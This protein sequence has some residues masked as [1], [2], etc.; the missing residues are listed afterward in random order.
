MLS[1]EN[2][3]A[4]LFNGPTTKKPPSEP[5]GFVDDSAPILHGRI[6]RHGPHFV[7]GVLDNIVCV[8]ADLT[9][10][11]RLKS[12]QRRGVAEA[13]GVPPVRCWQWHDQW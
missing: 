7:I 2:E 12:N 10:Q 1:P 3:P 13:I 11:K 9:G 5:G 6:E 4:A 8:F